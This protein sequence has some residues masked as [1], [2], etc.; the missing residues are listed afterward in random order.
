MESRRDKIKSFM[1]CR[2]YRRSK[3][4]SRI[5]IIIFSSLAVKMEEIERKVKKTCTFKPKI[6][7]NPKLEENKK[8]KENRFELLYQQS[9]KRINKK[10]KTKEEYEIEKI[11]ECT[12]KPSINK[13]YCC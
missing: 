4:K 12:F 6:N 11:Q 8:E 7:E 5:N 2:I 9:A 10:D 3:K 13:K 1:I